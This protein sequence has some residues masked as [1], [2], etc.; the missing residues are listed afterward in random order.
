MKPS[1]RG[2]ICLLYHDVLP[3]RPPAGGGPERFAVSSRAFAEQLDIIQECGYLGC[4]IA[5][6]LQQPGGSCVALSFDDGNLGQ[7]ERA[8]PALAARNMTATFFVT[9]SW[10]GQPGY[11]TWDQL[12]EMK[13]AGMSIQSHTQTHRFLSELPADQLADELWR[14]KEELDTALK[15]STDAIALPGGDRPRA[16]LRHLLA[17]AGYR[18]VATSRWGA[19]TGIG[20]SSAAPL[21]IRRCTV[22]GE[23]SA[24]YF[25]RV[26]TGDRRLAARR[27]MR[28]LA[29]G[30]IR[31]ALGPSRYANMRRRILEPLGRSA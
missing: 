25:R 1:G 14:S 18:V 24:A 6:A 7:F 13:S 8:F 23:P 30:G 3:G 9:T 15:Q 5:A 20:G 12:R 17:E 22:K 4:S 10:V 26:V 16:A 21:Q 2:W 11:V 31:R 29:L 28:E 27:R 19:N